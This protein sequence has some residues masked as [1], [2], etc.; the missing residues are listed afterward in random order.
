M[1]SRA[2]KSHL[3]DL[4]LE[5]LCSDS[6]PELEN[7]VSHKELLRCFYKDCLANKERKVFSAFGLC[8]GEE[9]ARGVARLQ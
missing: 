5:Y 6:F 9:R 3:T 2:F 8:V 7:S 1:N 4:Y